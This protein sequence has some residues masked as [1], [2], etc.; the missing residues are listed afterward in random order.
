[1]PEQSPLAIDA[2]E[3]DETLARLG[4][5][6]ELLHEL[7]AAFLGDAPQKL[8]DVGEAVDQK[9][10]K[11]IKQ[12]AHALKGAAAAVG[13]VGFKRLAVQLEIAAESEDEFA[14]YNVHQRLRD[15]LEAVI[16]KI[17]A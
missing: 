16:R 1:M 6:V 17:K 7:Y 13:A 11:R 2:L 8:E 4:G 10:F 5:D 3:I 12:K 15:A 9:D 14:A